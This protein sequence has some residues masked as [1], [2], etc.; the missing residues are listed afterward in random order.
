[1]NI[2]QPA[3]KLKLSKISWRPL[4]PLINFSPLCSCPPHGT[5]GMISL[6]W[7]S[8]KYLYIVTVYEYD[9]YDNT[10][11]V[12]SWIGKPLGKEASGTRTLTILR[13]YQKALE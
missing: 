7:C 10:H 1:M 6:N 5:E 13:T 11:L 3:E 12:S 9:P 8:E 2:C 4:V